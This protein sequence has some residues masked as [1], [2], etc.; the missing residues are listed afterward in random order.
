MKFFLNN[1][2]KIFKNLK[3]LHEIQI[4]AAAAATSLLRFPLNKRMSG[5]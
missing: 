2:L 3:I 5:K 4:A 1:K